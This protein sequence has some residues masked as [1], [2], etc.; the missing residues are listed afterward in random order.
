MKPADYVVHTGLPDVGE[1]SPHPS[2]VQP[3]AHFK[4]EPTSF[5]INLGQL[6]TVSQQRGQTQITVSLVVLPLQNEA[7]QWALLR[8]VSSPRHSYVAASFEDDRP[9]GTVSHNLRDN[10]KENHLLFLLLMKEYIFWNLTSDASLF[11]DV[12]KNFGY[13]PH[14]LEL[15]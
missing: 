6:S 3:W 11:Q 14:N 10:F 13:R 12:R 8:E 5:L 2:L 15:V 9:Y 4:Y 1:M 7:E